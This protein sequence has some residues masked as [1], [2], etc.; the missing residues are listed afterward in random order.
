MKRLPLLNLV[1]TVMIVLYLIIQMYSAPAIDDKEIE[2]YI[3][4]NPKTIISSLEGYRQQ[5]ESAAP[6]ANI[7]EKRLFG[8]VDDPKIGNPNA[9]I[10]I[11][12]FF[13]Y[14][15]GYCRKMFSVKQKLIQTNN[16]IL[17]IS[18]EIPMLSEKSAIMT[19]ASL[20]AYRAAP[21][22]YMAYQEALFNLKGRTTDADVFIR[23][24]GSVGIDERAF[25]KAFDDVKKHDSIINENAELA[26]GI[27]VRGTPAYII[28]DEL[29]PGYIS[30]EN[31]NAKV[32]NRREATEN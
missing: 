22:K 32:A 20:A 28:G 14:T 17:I 12:E 21:T 6:S 4:N 31:F 27:G 9:K 29:I 15:C 2:K 24:A 11:V 23:L 26:R 10:K 1:L 5:M 7:D 16:D 8:G 3:L 30:Y 18:R 13:D 19:R 25:K